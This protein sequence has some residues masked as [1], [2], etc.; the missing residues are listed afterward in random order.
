MSSCTTQKQLTYLQDIDQPGKDKYF[1]YM[2]PEYRLQKQD[3]LYV[4]FT[5]MNEEI[6]TSLNG[7]AAG[8]QI[9]HMAMRGG[10]Y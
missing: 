2:K 7:G 1:P 6:N 8:G 3:I 9:A 10:A 5:S 4:K